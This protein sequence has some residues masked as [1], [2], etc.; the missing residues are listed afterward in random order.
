M[1]GRQA[2]VR[3]AGWAGKRLAHLLGTG[4]GGADK[5]GTGRTRQGAAAYPVV[6][7]EAAVNKIPKQMSIS[8]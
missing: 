5:A 6:P 4:G 8:Y 7:N 3:Q 1:A 2:G